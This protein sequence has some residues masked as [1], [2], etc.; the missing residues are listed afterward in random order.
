[1][2]NGVVPKK[3]NVIYEWIIYDIC[4]KYRPPAY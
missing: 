3:R 4:E 2:W 1:M